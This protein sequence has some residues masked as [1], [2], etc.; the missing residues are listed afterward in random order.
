MANSTFMQAEAEVR[1]LMGRYWNW[2][3]DQTSF[4]GV[5]DWIKITTPYLDRHN[6]HLQ[7]YARPDQGVWLLT[8]DGYVIDD[9][10]QSGC[11][12]ESPKGQHMLKCALAGLGV[13]LEGGALVVK[14]SRIDFA[15]SKHNLVQA[16]LLVGGLFCTMESD[17]LIDG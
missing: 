10:V 8:D 4:R 1:D 15:L 13:N 9:L 6:D 17:G 3:R 14:T 11:K 2:L 12:V 16:M 7:I 5:S